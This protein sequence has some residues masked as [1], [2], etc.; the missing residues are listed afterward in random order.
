LRNKAFLLSL[1][2]FIVLMIKSFT[3]YELPSNFDLLV[4][5]ALTLL[6]A[7]GIIIDPSTP[8]IKDVEE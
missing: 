5:T 3:G 8:N 6:S 7:L 4:D 2:A 1:V